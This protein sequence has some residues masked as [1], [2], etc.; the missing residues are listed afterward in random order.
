MTSIILV[1]SLIYQIVHHPRFSSTDFS[2]VKAITS[3]AAH[4]PVQLLERLRSW[5]PHV[6]R[7]MEGVFPVSCYLKSSYVFNLGYG[8]SECV[9]DGLAILQTYAT[10]YFPFIRQSYRL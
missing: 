4:L 3:G 8:M 9:S 10:N 1:P 7:L 5:F 6:K 2:T